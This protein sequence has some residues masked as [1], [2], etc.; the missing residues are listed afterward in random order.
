M[1]AQRG[2]LGR[3]VAIYMWY[4]TTIISHDSHLTIISHDGHLTILSH[5]SHLKSTSNGC[6]KR[7]LGEVG[8][9]GILRVRNR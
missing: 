9:C 7:S 5:D 8:A 3:L 1:A 4:L 2:V 6:S